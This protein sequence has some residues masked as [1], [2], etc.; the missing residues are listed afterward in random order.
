MQKEGRGVAPPPLMIQK[1]GGEG[2]QPLPLAFIFCRGTPK[3][4]WILFRRHV[5]P[6]TTNKPQN[7]NKT[8]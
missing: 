7:Q 3:H 4:M 1:D 2:V 6:Q 8:E 5:G